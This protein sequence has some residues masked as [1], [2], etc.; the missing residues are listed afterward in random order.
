MKAGIVAAGDLKKS[1]STNPGELVE[2]YQTQE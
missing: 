2:S 1:I